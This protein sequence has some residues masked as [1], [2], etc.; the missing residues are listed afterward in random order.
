MAVAFIPFPTA[1][2]AE[3]GNRTGT[4]FYALSIT[5]ARLLTAAEWIFANRTCLVDP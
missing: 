5:L 4:I 3:N 1:V 2:I